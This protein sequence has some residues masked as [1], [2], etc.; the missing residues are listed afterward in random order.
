VVRLLA[1]VSDT[2][3]WEMWMW[4]NLPTTSRVL[5]GSD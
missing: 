5:L 2:S 1:P 3:G 4:H